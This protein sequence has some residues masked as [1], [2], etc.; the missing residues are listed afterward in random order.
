[1]PNTDNAINLL[2]KLGVDTSPS[3]A[4]LNSQIEALSKQLEGLKVDIKLDDKAVKALEN[5]GKIDLGKLQEDIEKVGAGLGDIGGQAGKSGKEALRSL[6]DVQKELDGIFKHVGDDLRESMKRG[7]SDVDELMAAYEGLK[8]KFTGEYEVVTEESTGRQ[9]KRVK[10]LSVEFENLK[11]QMERLRFSDHER[12]DMGEGMMPEFLWLPEKESRFID[13]KIKET[14]EGIERATTALNKMGSE[15]KLSAEQIDKLGEQLRKV[16]DPAGL[17]DYNKTLQGTLQ[18]NKDL[19]KAAKERYEVEEN[20][21]KLTNQIVAAQAKDP[22]GMGSSSEVSGMLSELEKINP[23]SANAAKSVKDV[24][25]NFER[26]KAEA[27]AAGR[28]SMGV[29]DSFRVAMEKFP[30]WMAASTA[31]YG[32]VRTI[33]DAIQQIVEL[34]AQITVLRRVAGDGVDVNAVLEDSV[35][36]AKQLGNEIADINDGFIAFA[37]QGFRGEELVM[38][39]EYATLLGNISDLS[40]DESSS[41]LTAAMKG[42]NIEAERAIHI[43]DAL[44]ETDNNYSITTKQLAQAM[45]RSAGA[46]QA[47]GKLN[48]A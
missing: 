37:R 2:V 11:G 33:R 17:R 8:P 31:F 46:A 7:I 41:T 14:Q 44:N 23:A 1:M 20:I 22:K 26:M 10:A 12:I 15:G 48:A 21:R 9:I 32:T 40:V 27:T 35:R 47:Y 19:A 39:S 13:T 4:N 28:E 38:L 30:V 6:T 25:D 43:V 18:T 42:F 36:L 24:S 29:M 45:E 16:E 5:L 34:D 3:K